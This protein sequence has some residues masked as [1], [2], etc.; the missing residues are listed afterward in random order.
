[1]GDFGNQLIGRIGQQEDK[2]GPAFCRTYKKES[3]LRFVFRNV[4]SGGQQI[5]LFRQHGPL[6]T[7]TQQSPHK[8]HGHI[9]LFDGFC[10]PR[11]PD[12]IRRKARGSRKDRAEHRKFLMCS[13]IFE[14]LHPLCSAVRSLREARRKQ[15]GS[16]DILITSVSRRS[17]LQEWSFSSQEV[18]RAA[19][20]GWF[21]TVC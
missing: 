10:R 21:D 4:A 20:S 12:P 16:S 5:H 17:L 9:S 2:E 1:M 18:R 14:G 15:P 11:Q 7:R 3:G 13:L 8:A 6:G 19:V